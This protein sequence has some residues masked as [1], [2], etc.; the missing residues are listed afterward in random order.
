MEKKVELV[1]TISI[2]PNLINYDIIKTVVSLLKVKYE[3]TCNENDGMIT[4]ISYDD[5]ISI[6]NIISK[7]STNVLFSIKFLANVVKPEKKDVISFKPSLI[8]DKGL[9]GKIYDNISVFIP[10][11][12]MKEWK[13]EKD[14]YKNKD[15][16][17][18]KETVVNAV[19]TDTKFNTT[20]YNCICTLLL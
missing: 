6:D 2:T 15:K 12:N 17:I 14:K 3:K 7:D 9:F 5:I 20:K 4:H 11:T 10:E 16:I 19:I 8:L 1:K 18:D 13:F